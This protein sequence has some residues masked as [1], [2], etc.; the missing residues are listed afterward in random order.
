MVSLFKEPKFVRSKSTDQ[1]GK[2]AWYKLLVAL[3]N[4]ITSK[5]F[6]LWVPIHGGGTRLCCINC[7][8]HIFH[9]QIPANLTCCREMIFSIAIS[10]SLSIK[11]GCTGLRS[12]QS[13]L[14]GVLNGM[15]C[16]T[17]LLVFTCASVCTQ[18]HVDELTIIDK[19]KYILITA[20]LYFPLQ[21]Y[22]SYI[23]SYHYYNFILTYTMPWMTKDL[24]VNVVWFGH[25]HDWLNQ[26][27]LID[28]TTFHSFS[29]TGHQ[30]GPWE[31]RKLLG[32]QKAIC[33]YTFFLMFSVPFWCI[34]FLRKDKWLNICDAAA[35]LHWFRR[36]S[37]S[38]KKSNKQWE[39]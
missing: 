18:Q 34:L 21:Q 26:F 12:D 2:F 11:L 39:E 19:H 25:V 6:V 28:L 33:I 9:L 17:R 10:P 1:N 36:W 20:I 23:V 38:G 13:W 32:L 14:A 29:Y 37:S 31:I 24:Y 8:T 4:L 5:V 27:L 30:C 7:Q 15:F 3:L 16:L 22:V 35:F